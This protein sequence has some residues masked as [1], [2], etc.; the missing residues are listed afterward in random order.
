MVWAARL[1][2]KIHEKIEDLQEAMAGSGSIEDGMG[3]LLFTVV[4]LARHLAV[5]TEV[6]LQRAV[7]RFAHRF[8]AME[9]EGPLEGLTLDELNAR[10][11]SAK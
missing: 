2:L 5:D 3:D 1:L 4:N 9:S 8:R 10:W 7:D 6:A 11:E